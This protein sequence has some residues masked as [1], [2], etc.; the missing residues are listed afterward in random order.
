MTVP[1]DSL[2]PCPHHLNDSE[3]AAL[4]LAGVTAYRALFTRAQLKSSD[5]VLI[6]GLGGGVSSLGALFAKAI[7]ANVYG[8]SGSDQKL[9]TMRNDAGVTG[10]NYK[11]DTWV[12]DVLKSSGGIDVILDG[13][14]GPG[15]KSLLK[16][17]RPGGRV[18]FYGGT[19][20][21]WPEILPQHL[22]YRQVSIVASTMGSPRDFEAMLALVSAHQIKPLVWKTIEAEKTADAFTALQTH[23]QLGKVVIQIP[24]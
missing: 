15:F 6:T 18:S 5:N 22:F 12:K 14:G 23:A 3:A 4:P 24:H 17:L 9:E 2:Y 16:L 10:F 13:S 21:K 1:A 7:G 19:C 20:G 8:T 11:S